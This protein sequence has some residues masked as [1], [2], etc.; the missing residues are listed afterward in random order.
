MSYTVHMSAKN[1]RCLIPPDSLMWLAERFWSVQILKEGRRYTSKERTKLLLDY[2][3]EEEQDAIIG[4]LETNRIGEYYF[5]LEPEQSGNFKNSS[6]GGL[7][8]LLK[9]FE[10]N[11]IIEETGEDGEQEVYKY[12]HGK[13]KKGKVVFD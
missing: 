5:V 3:W 13:K 6:D 4:F 10:G 8:I 11:G 9:E 2:E 12:E 7:S 1:V